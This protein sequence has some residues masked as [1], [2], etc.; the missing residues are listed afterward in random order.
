VLAGIVALTVTSFAIEFAANTLLLR[1]LPQAFPTATALAQNP[2]ARG[3]MLLYTALSVA[4]GGYVTAWI[5]RRTPVAHAVV[6]GI[7]MVALTLLQMAKGPHPAPL[8]SW[9]V[10]I[11]TLIPGA[12]YGGW[13]RTRALRPIMD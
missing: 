9:I 4:F 8:W 3:F 13:L 1:L 7:V 5:A 12:W 10:G 6:M 11:A 2:A